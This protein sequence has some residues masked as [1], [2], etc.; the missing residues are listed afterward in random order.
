MFNLILCWIKI[1]NTYM[2]VIYRSLLWN[3]TNAYVSI[4]TIKMKN[5]SNLKTPKGWSESVNRRTD[6][7]MAKRKKENYGR[8]NNTQN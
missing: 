2:Y 6:N 8:Q 4:V 3:E 1:L 5:E 7:K